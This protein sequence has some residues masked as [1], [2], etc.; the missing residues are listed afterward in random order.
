[1]T[2]EELA[3]TKA[4]LRKTKAFNAQRAFLLELA[5]AIMRDDKMLY[6]DAL[7]EAAADWIAAEHEV[8]NP[9]D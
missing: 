6:P 3:R 2:R 4:T 7:T 1:M 5:G 9:A 8:L